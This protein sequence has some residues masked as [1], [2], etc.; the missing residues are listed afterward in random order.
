MLEYSV[1]FSSDPTTTV[2]PHLP[3]ILAKRRPKVC[4]REAKQLIRR[5]KSWCKKLESHRQRGLR[6]LANLMMSNET[7]KE[8]I[9]Y[10]SHITYNKWGPTCRQMTKM[11]DGRFDQSKITSIHFSETEEL[12]QDKD[13]PKVLVVRKRRFGPGTESYEQDL[14]DFLVTPGLSPSDRAHLKKVWNECSLGGFFTGIMRGDCDDTKRVAF[15]RCKMQLH[16][17]NTDKISLNNTKRDHNWMS[18]RE[19]TC[20]NL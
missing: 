9:R 20:L 1:S 7:N 2:L 12:L 3:R 17:L 18:P 10:C 16:M 11:W 4:K 6:D 8:V 19:P 13:R 15:M 14:Q 5:S